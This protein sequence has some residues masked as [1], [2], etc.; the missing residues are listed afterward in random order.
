E[1]CVHVVARP[2]R[3]LS[4][5]TFSMAQAP[6]AVEAKPHRDG[7]DDPDAPDAR[8]CVTAGLLEVSGGPQQ[9][10]RGAGRR[11]DL[12]RPGARGA[13]DGCSPADAA[14]VIYDVLLPAVGNASGHTEN[15][16]LHHVYSVPCWV[17]VSGTSTAQHAGSGGATVVMLK[18]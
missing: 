10:A 1:R 16:D 3:P 6:V 17:Y 4:D 11:H 15:E 7:A 2:P 13:D 8:A 14:S 12:A 18:A 5:A 9:Y